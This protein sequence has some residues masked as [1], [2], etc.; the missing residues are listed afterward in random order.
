MSKRTKEQ[1]QP[2]F[3]SKEQAY[4][5]SEWARLIDTALLVV[6][7]HYRETSGKM[8]PE[9]KGLAEWTTW[10]IKEGYQ[11]NSV[12]VTLKLRELAGNS[13]FLN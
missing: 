1:P 13:N 6:V 10:M 8:N 12:T 3:S 11:Y 5:S 2:E 9:I 4:K 7:D